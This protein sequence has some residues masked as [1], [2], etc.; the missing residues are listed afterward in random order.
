MKKRLINSI[1]EQLNIPREDLESICQIVYSVAGQMALASLWDYDEDHDSVS[2]QHFKNRVIKIFDAYSDLF[3]EISTLFLDDKTGLAE[4]I[5]TVYLHNGLMYHSANRVSPVAYAEAVSDNVCLLK[6]A[7]PDLKLF[8]S[9]LGFYTAAQQPTDKTIATL[10]GLQEQSFESYLEEMLGYDQWKEITW[11]DNTEFLRL[12]PPFTRGYW[13]QEPNCDDRISIARFGEPNRIYMFYRYIDGVFQYK[14]IP[15]WCL[16]D[17][18]TNEANDMEYI[19]IAVGLLMRYGTLPKIEVKETGSQLEIKV[20]YR[21]PPSEEYFFRLYS[22]PLRFDFAPNETQVFIR[23]M[24]KQIYP[25]FKK[26]MIS[27]GYQFVEELL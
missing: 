22:W 26:E 9:G 21:F 6:G 20:G 10:F 23:K 16:K 15:E 11:P 5:Y 4:D 18:F 3:P 1:G 8:M 12:D 2:V 24:S 27:I 19:R 14:T 7:S 25:V 13:Q 17:Y